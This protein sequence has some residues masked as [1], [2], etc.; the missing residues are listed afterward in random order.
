MKEQKYIEEYKRYIPDEV[1][2]E[3]IYQ[4]TEYLEKE[5]RYSLTRKFYHHGNTTIFEHCRN[6]AFTSCYIARKLHLCVNY[7]WFIRGALLHDYYF[8]DWHVKEKGHALHGLRHPKT[9]WKN[10]QQDFHLE[11]VEE[12]II[13]CHM[14]PLILFP[15]LTME[16]WIVCIADKICAVNEVRKGKR[17]C[18]I[19]EGTHAT[20]TKV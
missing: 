7:R 5:G 6:V 1:I 19:K 9:A 16:G 17:E 14:F 10:A 18:K 13:L 11:E 20:K 3:M 15:P 12:N 2:S 4:I 8:Y